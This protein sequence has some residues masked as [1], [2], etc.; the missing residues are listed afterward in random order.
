MP[1]YR[2]AFVPGGTFFFTVVVH[3]R[4]RLFEDAAAISLLGSVLAPLPNAMAVYRQRN[5]APARSLAHD[6]VTPTGRHRVLS[7]VGL[8]QEGVHQTVALDWRC[9]VTDL[10]GSKNVSVDVECGSLVFGNTRSRMTM[11]FSIISIT[12]IGIQSSMDTC[13]ARVIGRIRVSIDG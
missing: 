4:R 7:S 12:S 5:R 1:D 2:R 10:A 3:G 9:T 8:A 13:D 6:L 11:I